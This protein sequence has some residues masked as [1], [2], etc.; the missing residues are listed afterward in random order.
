M[1]S[2]TPE[3][4]RTTP[5]PAIIEVLAAMSSEREILLAYADLKRRHLPR[6]PVAPWPYR[7]LWRWGWWVRPPLFAGFWLGHATSWELEEVIGGGIM[8][9]AFAGYLLGIVLLNTN[10]S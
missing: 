3:G 9:G 5:L 2:V 6:Y 8:S 4:L 1:D 7:R 10:L